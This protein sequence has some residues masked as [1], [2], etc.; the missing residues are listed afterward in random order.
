MPEPLAEGDPMDYMVY[1]S[2]EDASTLIN[3]TEP[4]NISLDTRMDSRT[5]S[6]NPT[7]T[8]VSQME[9][10]DM[11]NDNEL[12]APPPWYWL[13]RFG[14]MCQS[15]PGPVLVLR[16]GLQAANTNTKTVFGQAPNEQRVHEEPMVETSG[17]RNVLPAAFVTGRVSI[18]AVPVAAEVLKVGSAKPATGPSDSEPARESDNTI[19]A[20]T[21]TVDSE[22]GPSVSGLAEK[23]DPTNS[24]SRSKKNRRK[25]K[26]SRR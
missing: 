25:N 19:S 21:P 20:N 13:V 22:I 17:P 2:E 14:H 11:G 10:Y 23:P 12:Y 9:D 15:P 5:N 7:S 8:R 18:L 1:E 26:R 24:G 16:G 3:V 6:D 4:K